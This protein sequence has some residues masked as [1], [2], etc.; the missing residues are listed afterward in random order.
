VATPLGVDGVLYFLGSMNVVRAV[1][2]RS[3]KRRWQ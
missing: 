1:D 3:G 2:A